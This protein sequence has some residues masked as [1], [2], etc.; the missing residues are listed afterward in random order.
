MLIPQVPDRLQSATPP[1]RA[2]AN[3]PSQRISWPAQSSDGRSAATCLQTGQVSALPS[4]RRTHDSTDADLTRS[5]GSDC[6]PA[7]KSAQLQA[8]LQGGCESEQRHKSVEHRFR[9]LRDARDASGRPQ[10]VCHNSR[11]ENA[12]LDGQPP[13]RVTFVF[14]N[15]AHPGAAPPQDPDYDPRT[16]S[17]PP[18]EQS[19]L[20]AVPP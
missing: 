20:C 11:L 4:A 17:I 6:L 16:I 15:V 18:V 8:K 13:G 10:Q 1:L 9:W 19:K 2:A 7:S 5:A 3:A 12:C 14:F